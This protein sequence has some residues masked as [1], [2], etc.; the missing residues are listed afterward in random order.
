MAPD[1]ILPIKHLTFCTVDL[2]HGIYFN[3]NRKGNVEFTVW[4]ANFALY[5]NLDPRIVIHFPCSH[6]MAN[7]STKSFALCELADLY[8]W[9]S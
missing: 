4:D 5:Y 1:K 6:Q 3:S 2:M 8:S 7:I 9:N